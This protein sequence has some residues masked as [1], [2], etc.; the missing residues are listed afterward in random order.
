[1]KELVLAI[2]YFISNFFTFIAIDVERVDEVLY[3]QQ[4]NFDRISAEEMNLTDKEKQ[5]CREWFDDNILLKNG[6]KELP[7]NFKFGTKTLNKTLDEWDFDVSRESE[8]G[9]VF[10]GGKT[11]YITLK[12]KTNGIVATVEATIYEENATCDWTVFIKNE[13]SENSD[14]ISNFYALDKTFQTGDSQVYY[15]K[16][17]RDEAY[18]FVMMNKNLNG[19][20]LNF[21]SI[22]GRS[23]D[24]YLPYFNVSGE[25]TGLVLGV[26]WSGFWKLNL[27][28][29]S[30]SR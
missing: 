28:E 6:V 1:M 24:N 3:N 29:I 4:I 10:R 25:N 23:T 15:S 8:S 7:Y 9:E 18:D 13:G 11:S 14:T 12:H 30:S 19:C 21:N 27:K 20:G 2:I 26:G 22:E 17:S 16:G 5:K